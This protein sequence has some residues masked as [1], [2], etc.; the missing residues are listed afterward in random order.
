MEIKKVIFWTIAFNVAF[1]VQWQTSH[2]Y[3]DVYIL[4]WYENKPFFVLESHAVSLSFNVLFIG[5][6]FR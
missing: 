4:I 3:Y 1:H 2:A 5:L 6:Y